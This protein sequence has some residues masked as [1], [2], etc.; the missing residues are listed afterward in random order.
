MCDVKKKKGKKLKQMPQE[1]I[2]GLRNFFAQH[3]LDPN[4]SAEELRS[5]LIKTLEYVAY[6]AV[7]P[8]CLQPAN[9][10][11]RQINSNGARALVLWWHHYRDFE[12]HKL[13][14]F[15]EEF[16]TA[17]KQLSRGGEWAKLLL[18]DVIEERPV[19]PGENRKNS[20]WYRITEDGA[21]WVLREIIIERYCYTY[22]GL[23]V[24][25]W[26]REQYVNI[27]AALSKKFSYKDLL[28]MV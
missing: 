3:P 2:D 21:R 28:Q 17:T 13:T 11:E 22:V 1:A 18:W 16:P 4:V 20:G 7:C 24:L 23:K 5:N 25:G 12:Y 26:D 10:Y 15:Y 14:E 19:K 6:G 9:S 27:D 8:V